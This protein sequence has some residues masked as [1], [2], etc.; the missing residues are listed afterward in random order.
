MKKTTLCRNFSSKGVCPSGRRCEFAH[1]EDELERG[2]AACVAGR[3]LERVKT[4]DLS[5]WLEKSPRIVHN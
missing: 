3:K 2:L 4:Y 5:A 1:G